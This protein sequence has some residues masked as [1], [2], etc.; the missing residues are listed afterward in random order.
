M[1]G[2]HE[3]IV[4]LK[5]AF[6][7]TGGSLGDIMNRIPHSAHADEAR[8]VIAI[9][10]LIAKGELSATDAWAASSKDEKA[11]LVRRKQADKEANEAE[12]LAKELGVWD[13][14]Y[15]SGKAGPRKG[16]GKKKAKRGEDEEGEGEEEEDH[17]ALQALILKKRQNAGAF[18]DNLAAKY[19]E[20][21]EPR[22][23]KGKRKND[24]GGGA[25]GE[26]PRKR[27]RRDADTDP[28]DDDEF[29]RLQQTLFRDKGVDKVA[30]AG[31]SVGKNTRARRARKP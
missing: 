9:S 2:S 5:T 16:K 15:G 11:R 20:Q 14:F 26:S 18:L 3:E 4:D 23:K 8:F 6:E 12:E 29:E 17:S 22:A 13:E 19:A 1:A 27:K 28:I 10:D 21:P 30:E 7:E 31:K 25:D 24:A